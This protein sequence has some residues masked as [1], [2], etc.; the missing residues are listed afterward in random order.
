MGGGWVGHGRE[1]D[2]QEKKKE[3]TISAGMEKR[4]EKT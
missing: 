2:R 1:G 3:P 4:W